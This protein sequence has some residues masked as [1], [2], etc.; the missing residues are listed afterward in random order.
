MFGVWPVLTGFGQLSH[1]LFFI[2]YFSFLISINFYRGEQEKQGNSGEA[3]I[4]E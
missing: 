3:R 1:S 4:D 2:S